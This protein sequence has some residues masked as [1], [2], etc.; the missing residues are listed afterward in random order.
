MVEN[1]LITFE[2]LKTSFKSLFDREFNIH[3][4]LSTFLSNGIMIFQMYY[5]SD[6]PD[7]Q[8]KYYGFFM[9]Y[10]VYKLCQ[11]FTS[12]YQSTYSGKIQDYYI[13]RNYLEMNVSY[14]KGLFMSVIIHIITYFP[15]KWIVMFI[16]T[17]TYL[18]KQNPEFVGGSIAK[19]GEYITIHFWAVLC[20]CL[21]NALTQILSLLNYNTFITYGNI[22]RILFNI[23]FGVFYRKKYGD[24]YFIT[25]LSYADVFGELF[26]GIYLIIIIQ[27]IIHPL[28]QD[29]FSFNLDLIKS[30]FQTLFEVLNIFKFI[31][32]FLL[33]FYDE[34]F[35]LL[36]VFFFIEKY[37]ISFYN[38]FFICFI[39]KNMFFKFPRNDKLTIVSFIRKVLNESSENLSINQ[40]D[41]EHDAR[42]QTNKNYEWKFFVKSKIS[43]LLVLNILM[44]ITYIFFYL[45]KGFFIVQITYLNFFVI[46]LFALNAIIEQL[47]L[48]VI[49][50]ESC[51]KKSN[52][53]I[54]DI[55]I[56]L[57][58]AIIGFILMFW[59][60]HSMGGVTLV[61]YFMYYYVFF[62]LDSWGKNYD[63][64]LI[65][66]NMDIE[67]QKREEENAE[68]MSE[69]SFHRI[70]P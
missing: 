3:L 37:E 36:Y 43:N 32:Y 16:F 42:S 23:C 59:I 55:L 44:A 11:L 46:F 48:F 24:I 4:F 47:A 56:G 22:I 15:M 19:V 13:E 49:N 52:Q 14:K 34:I 20:G 53:S 41:Y 33:N 60:S 30:S 31:F 10:I 51:I 9:G 63:I 21:T 45:L 66:M 18:K 5:Y 65:N 6:L 35:M 40:S 54:Q 68:E 12:Y 64:M 39:F 7:L 1:D 67:N 62:R 28:S 8:E 70:I 25:G 27:H 50:V 2:E 57:C 61:I 17:N 38:F 58:G 29:Y 26:V 69:R